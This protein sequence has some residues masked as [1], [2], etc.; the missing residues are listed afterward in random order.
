MKVFDLFEK[1]NHLRPALKK[2]EFYT[3]K[4][5]DFGWEILETINV[6]E[7]RDEDEELSKRFS[8]G[9]KALYF[10][11]YLDAQ[12]TNGGF[13]QFYFNEYRK[14]LPT[15]KEGLKLISDTD[16]LDLVIKADNE[17]LINQSFF[18]QKIIKGD[19]IPI[20]DKLTV[21]SEID[22]TYFLL[23]DKTMHLI[24]KYAK[25]NPDEFVA[26]KN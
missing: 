8:P 16:L 15:I 12:V 10:F 2:N 7:S 21:F 25:S 14:Y 9:Q 11:W 4:G 20:Y 23:H 26:F 22:D 17:Y 24:E 6:A 13:I 18:N 19:Q 1:E 3:L 5:W